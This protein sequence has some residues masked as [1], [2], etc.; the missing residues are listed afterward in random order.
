MLWIA[1]FLAVAALS[2]LTWMQ[3]DRASRAGEI[4]EEMRG[5]RDAALARADSAM[6]EG[7]KHALIA[8]SLRHSLISELDRYHASEDQ[9]Q[10]TADSLSARIIDMVPVGET[11]ER[12]AVAVAELRDTYERR[13]DDLYG[14]LEISLARSAALESRALSA[15]RV[16]GHLADALRA[17]EAERDAFRRALNPGLRERLKDHLE[18]AS[19]AAIVGMGI[20]IALGI[21]SGA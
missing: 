5:E 1:G 21:L 17:T 13:L 11:Q 16:S 12:V 10:A 3:Y 19:L 18:V 9:L 4:I 14:L 20:G 6:R 8:D 7:R 15:E 2:Y